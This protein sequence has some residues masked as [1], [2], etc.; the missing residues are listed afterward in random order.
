MNLS[1]ELQNFLLSTKYQMSEYEKTISVTNLLD[2]SLFLCFKYININKINETYGFDHRIIC[3]GNLLKLIYNNHI[4]N[5][6]DILNDT[7][8]KYYIICILFYKLN[9]TE[10][11]ILFIKN[12]IKIFD[13]DLSYNYVNYILDVSDEINYIIPEFINDIRQTIKETY[14]LSSI[15]FIKSIIFNS[16]TMKSHTNFI[17]WCFDSSIF[18]KKY[19]EQNNNKL[20]SDLSK[21]LFNNKLKKMEKMVELLNNY[22]NNSEYCCMI[23][24]VILLCIDKCNNK[25]I[26]LSHGLYHLIETMFNVLHI[27]DTLNF[28]T[29]NKIND[30]MMMISIISALVHDL[31][32]HKYSSINILNSNKTEEEIEI[33]EMTILYDELIKLNINDKWVNQIKLIITKMSY[34][35]IKKFGLCEELKNFLPYKIVITADLFC[36]YD[37]ERCHIYNYNKIL[38]ENSRKSGVYIDHKHT[39]GFYYAVFEHSVK[40]FDNRTS[41]HKI[42]N[43]ILIKNCFCHATFLEICSIEQISK[44]R[45]LNCYL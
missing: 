13:N 32:D 34:S 27:I 6:N 42:N 37:I 18:F 16:N 29:L 24:N 10:D 44:Y 9:C 36:G 22:I 28:N 8:L 14:I 30:E 45:K 7:K 23:N 33:D 38:N 21:S 3:L 4:V 20:K 39:K 43:E 31:I 12:I 35:K 1:E 2:Y 11:L 26:D 19:C 15:D 25:N 5:H 41:Q 40:L 17:N